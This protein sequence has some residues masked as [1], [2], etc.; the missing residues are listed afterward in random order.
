VVVVV[1]WL[2]EVEVAVLS[3]LNVSWEE[4]DSNSFPPSLAD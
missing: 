4:E 2:V 3:R 1:L